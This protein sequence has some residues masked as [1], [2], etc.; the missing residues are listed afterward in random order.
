MCHSNLNGVTSHNFAKIQSLIAYNCIHKFEIIC[1]SESYLNSEILSSDSNLQ[2][3]GYN[4]ARIDHPSNT[5]CGGVCPYYECLLPLNVIDIS[6]LQECIN[7]VVK[8]GSKI[9]NFVSLYRSPSQTKDE[10][11]NFIK[12]LELNLEHIA[13]KSPFLIVVLGDFNARMQGSYQNDNNFR[14]V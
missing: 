2:I 10:F 1:L 9:C 6:Y 3:L 4:F 7:F 11:E 14:R 8:I 13:N 5:K 12:N